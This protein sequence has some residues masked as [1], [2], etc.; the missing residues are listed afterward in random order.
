MSIDFAKD[1]IQEINKLVCSVNQ[2]AD[3]NIRW[4]QEKKRWER[5][6][7]YAAGVTSVVAG[8]LVP[9]LNVLVDD[10][11]RFL[12]AVCGG[13]VVLS[14]SLSG[15]FRWQLNWMNYA[16]AQSQIEALHR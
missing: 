4:Y 10:H 6:L 8:A 14:T 5:R 16:A 13:L 2:I 7:Y 12:T 15:F 1:G 9:V 11:V 3:Q